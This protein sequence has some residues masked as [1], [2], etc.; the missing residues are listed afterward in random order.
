M[1]FPVRHLAV[2]IAGV[3]GLTLSSEAHA[4]CKAAYTVDDLLEDMD[5]MTEAMRDGEAPKLQVHGAELQ[6]GL[7]CMGAPANPQLMAS[8]YRMLGVYHARSDTIDQA[9]MW[10]RTAREIDPTYRFDISAVSE[11]SVT[12]T[13]YEEAGQVE[14]FDP[15][16]VPGKLLSVPANSKLLID[17][18]PLKV[19]AATPD[20][21][22]LIQQVAS[23]GGVRA[24]W[25]IVGN[26]IPARLL[27]DELQTLNEQKEEEEAVRQDRREQK[28]PRKQEELAGGYTSE[29]TTVIKRNRPAAKTP[30]MIVGAATLVAAGGVYAASFPA[31]NDFDSATEQA[32]LDQARALTNAMV[33]ASGG[34]LVLGAGVGAWGLLLDG[35]PTVG[36]SV[37]W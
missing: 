17:G 37:R 7:Q 3:V 20:R 19:A 15:V 32:E 11:G 25:L 22:H 34:V 28:R 27:R 9:P 21:F 29:D 36:L 10:F 33:L 18:R 4:E 5:S 35:N 30:L 26:E 16:A 24:T 23:G 2:L 8:V 6:A 13:L 12:F 14:G 1:E 31:R